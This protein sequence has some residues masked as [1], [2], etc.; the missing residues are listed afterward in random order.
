MK[1]YTVILSNKAQEDI[2][3]YIDYILYECFAEKTAEK[4]FYGIFE[5]IEYISKNAETPKLET[6]KSLLQFGL[7]VY[8]VNFKNMTFIYTVHGN[9]AYIHRFIPTKMLTDI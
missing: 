1:K 6:N 3:N 5:C 4:H 9:T 8:R 7:F 2:D